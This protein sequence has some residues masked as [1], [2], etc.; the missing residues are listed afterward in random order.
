MENSFS[1]SFVKSFTQSQDSP[2]RGVI[3]YLKISLFIASRYLPNF[4]SLYCNDTFQRQVL[5]V[6]K[7]CLIL[8][9]FQGVFLDCTKPINWL[10]VICK[11]VKFNFT[12]SYFIVPKDSV[13][14]SF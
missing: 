13:F 14:T 5:S 6:P 8:V 2:S 7:D 9:I 4:L 3:Y 11:K 12:Y 10:L 1:D